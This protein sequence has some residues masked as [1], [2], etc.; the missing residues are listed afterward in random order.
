MSYEHRKE[1]FAERLIQPSILRFGNAK[2]IFGKKQG[3]HETV[4]IVTMVFYC[5][6]LSDVAYVQVAFLPVYDSAR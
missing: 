1:A 4:D 3:A 6:A 2:E 5:C